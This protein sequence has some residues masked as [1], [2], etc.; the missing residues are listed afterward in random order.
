M[1]PIELTLEGFGVFPGRVEVN[2]A[3]LASRGLFLVAGETGSGKTTIF[4]AM[5]WAL[6]GEMPLKASGEVRSD[7]VDDATRCE[8]S[9]TFEAGGSRYRVTRNPDQLQPGRRS[10]SKLVKEPASATLM[11]IGD[12]G[13]TEIVADKVRDVTQTC[14]SVIGLDAEQFKRVVLLPQGEFNA[15]LLADTRKREEILDELFGGRIYDRIVEELKTERDRLTAELGSY[16]AKITA[17]L[18]GAHRS[19]TTAAEL[20]DVPTGTGDEHL[21]TGT[22]DENLPTGTGDGQP[23]TETVAGTG[24]RHVPTGTDA[25]HDAEARPDP[26]DLRSTRVRLGESLEAQR[27]AQRAATEAHDT[28]LRDH[29]DATGAAERFDRATELRGRLAELED[30]APAIAAAKAAAVASGAARPV[31]EAADALGGAEDALRNAVAERDTRR[32]D[33][34]AALD[35]LDAPTDPLTPAALTGRL[36][37]LRADHAT[38][39]AKLDALAAAE[40]TLANLRH[41]REALDETILATESARAGAATRLD[42]IDGLLP[43]L[44]GTAGDPEAITKA[45]D[46]AT[47]VAA[48]RARLEGLEAEFGTATEQTATAAADLTAALAAFTGTQ[49]PRLAQTLESGQ[50]CPVCG[51]T[52]HPV[53]ATTDDGV[54]VDWDHVSDVQGRHDESVAKLQTVTS[55]IDA[56]RGRLGDA[57]DRPVT[58]LEADVA[59]LRNDLATA[60][61]AVEKV[62]ALEAEQSTLT[63]RLQQLGM[64]LA[65]MGERRDRSDVDIDTATKALEIARQDATGLDRAVLDERAQSID[66]LEQLLDG[67]DT[68]VDTVTRCKATATGRRADLERLLA[69]SDHDDVASARAVLLTPDEETA[70]L[71]KADEHRGAIDTTRGAL[72]QLEAQGL[73]DARPDTDTAQSLLDEAAAV[74]S[75]LDEVVA[76]LAVNLDEADRSLGEFDELDAAVG[77]VRDRAAAA[78][79]AHQVCAKQGALLPV[80]LKRWVL[81]RE[82]DRITATANVHLATMTNGR[83]ALSRRRT[84]TDARRATGL[85]LEVDDAHTGRARSTQSLSGGEQFQASLALALGLADVISHGGTAGGQ[86]FE[87]LFV[88]EGFGSLS[89]DALDDAVE[90]LNHLQSTGRMVGAITHVESMKEALHVGIQVQR[91]DDGRGSTLTVHY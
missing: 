14:R 12:D 31:V 84:R 23:P 28:A 50:P 67:Y 69:A 80:S 51:S 83:Y 16:E 86:A 26:E 11:R 6:Y 46:A 30:A 47:T 90:T 79:R 38:A 89:A 33:I 68:L 59:S 66:R 60:T 25:E 74:R 18:D 19:L 35:G 48:D 32:T 7:H 37:T 72:G 77:D 87:A 15:F 91:R 5:C 21:P 63:G 73:P 45:I 81:A 55:K 56:L 22:G 75:R 42:E 20:I 39:V 29:Q 40:T 58:E 44:R 85:D 3:A 65:T 61:A 24:A 2:F 62:A 53:P 54:V 4:D 10:T 57:A 1:K 34:I 71:R 17:A 70:A 27:A 43:E 78:T 82:L 76:N 52:D 8:V 9:F 13:S 49:A 41:A 64:D 88:D 36:T